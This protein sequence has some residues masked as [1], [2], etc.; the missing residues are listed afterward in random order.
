MSIYIANYI[1]L[2]YNFPKDNLVLLW[3]F[4]DKKEFN[5]LMSNEGEAFELI[6]KQLLKTLYPNYN[7]IHTIYSHD[8]GKDFYTATENEKIWVEAKCY[9]RHL[10]LSRIAGT[11]VMADICEIN[12]III[13]S[14][15]KLSSGA[16]INFARYSSI[17]NKILIVYNDDDIINL[18]KHSKKI[19]I[20][21]KNYDTIK[22]L[23][24][25][26]QNLRSQKRTTE[27]VY[28]KKL[29]L[30]VANIFNAF[31]ESPIDC[32]EDKI[33]LLSDG[34][35]LQTTCEKINISE[36]SIRAFD[37]INAEIVLR[38]PS[39]HTSKNVVVTYAENND[40]YKFISSHIQNCFLEPGQCQTIRVVFRALNKTLDLTLP[41]YKIN[42]ECK[43][44]ENTENTNCCVNCRLIG[45]TP[46]LGNDNQ[47]LNQLNINLECPNRTFKTVLIY[48]RSGV[49]K[50]RFLQE[51]KNS[52]LILGNLIFLF[53][54]ENKCNSIFEFFRELL[55]GY[56]N[57]IYDEKTGKVLLP[58]NINDF[59]NENEVYNLKFIST[60]LNNNEEKF[61]KE[62]AKNWLI[63]NLKSNR[64]TILIDNAQNLNKEIFEFAND[65]MSDLQVC[66]CKSEIVLAFNTDLLNTTTSGFLKY[67]K[68]IIPKD[69]IIEIVGFNKEDA[70]Q[71]LQASLDPNKIRDDITHLCEKLIEKVNPT[72]LYL[73]QIVLYLYQKKIIVFHNENICFKSI[74]LLADAF[75]D[76]PENIH[77]T[78]VLRLNMLFDNNKSQ[79]QQIYDLFWSILIFNEFPLFFVKYIDGMENEI[80]NKCVE[81]GFLKYGN[82]NTLVFE[83]QLIAKSILIIVQNTAYTPNPIIH[84]ISLSK[85]TSNNFINQIF[86]KQYSCAKFVIESGNSELTCEKY[87]EYLN[88]LS[89]HYA[90]LQLIPYIINE[91]DKYN[92]L[93]HDFL[94][95][96]TLINT[97]YKL[98]TTCQDKLGVHKTSKMFENIIEFETK[99]YKYYSS[100]SEKFIELLKFY[101]FQLL[102]IDKLDFINKMEKIGL[103]LLD[104]K[105]DKDFQ[106]WLKWAQGKTAIQLHQFEKAKKLLQDGIH[107]AEKYNNKH[108][109]AEIEIQLSYIYS[110]KE[111]K[112]KAAYHWERASNY[113]DEEGI[114]NK[115]QKLI[116]K[117]NALLIRN[118][119]REAEKICYQVTEFYH[120]KDCYAYLKSIIVD[121]SSNLMVRKIIQKGIYDS[122]L[123][124]ELQVYLTQ[125]RSLALTYKKDEYLHAAYKTLAYYKFLIENYSTFFSKEDNAKYLELM[126]I[127][128][129]ELLDNYEWDNSD[130]CFFYPVFKDI[131]EIPNIIKNISSLSQNTFKLL[132]IMES[133]D[134]NPMLMPQLKHG[135]FNDENNKVN[136]FHHSYIW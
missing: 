133:K 131:S 127:L 87:A 113:F 39:L 67:Y 55:L 108:R 4:M 128:S 81:L 47:S 107:I 118:N 110:Y 77:N 68:N 105:S 60:I 45:E 70:L 6:V 85:K 121:F 48:G 106:V 11:F 19:P 80:V 123:D 83:H 79:I 29:D 54:G 92:S 35:Y 27:L 13:F 88:S 97:L 89:L 69:Y 31:A 91:V 100:E 132:K 32:E 61:D 18:I 124:K 38:N 134:N 44:Y 98:I 52:R 119:I 64:I 94:L 28:K 25:Q 102:P 115:V 114:Y 53:N 125:Y 73:K 82:D 23:K 2:W 72:P 135:I 78:I 37:L 136:L 117:G 8:G 26:L 50:S 76:L 116:S 65:L 33:E 16:F 62:V 56:Y 112:E 40:Y 43:I 42:F 21:A 22:E 130:F 17:N 63:S 3:G 66:N 129:E 71:Y 58:K 10:E 12:K 57:Y 14:K 30:F 93:Y 74:D 20:N 15:S 49:G 41:N 103:E 51:M 96:K 5:E 99:N 111:N 101:M 90:N 7:F 120:S 9:N 95:P 59:I 126:Y 34:Y 84:N 24:K 1:I 36:K 122:H 109:L 75:N 86:Q 104:N 46:Y